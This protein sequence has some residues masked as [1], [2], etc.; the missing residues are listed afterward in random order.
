MMEGEDM[1]FSVKNTDRS[2]KCL[3]RETEKGTSTSCI[4]IVVRNTE[5]TKLTKA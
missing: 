2:N 3:S 5:A 4:L 1:S